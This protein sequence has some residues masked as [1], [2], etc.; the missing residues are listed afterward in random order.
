[1]PETAQWNKAAE[2]EIASVKDREVYKIVPSSVWF[3]QTEANQF[4]LFERKADGSFK[5][6]VVAQSW[7]QVLGIDSGSIYA[8]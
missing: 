4:E 8:A 1:M 6:R 2:R 3:R 7:K 5:A